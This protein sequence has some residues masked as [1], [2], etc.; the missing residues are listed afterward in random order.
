MIS[1]LGKKLGMTEIFDEQGRQVPVTVL[2]V[3]PCTIT[4]LRVPEKHGYTAVQM[5]YGET[6][7]K[8]MNKPKLA[9]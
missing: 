4:E 6:K 9:Q 7:E 5:A 3:G 8:H 2:E 1:L